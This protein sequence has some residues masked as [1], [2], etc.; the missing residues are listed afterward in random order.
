[1]SPLTKKADLHIKDFQL[2]GIWHVIID[3]TLRSEF[4]GSCIDPVRNAE[5]SYV[6]PNGAIDAAVKS[7]LDNYHHDYSARNFLFLSAVMTTSGRISGDFLRLLYILAHR[8]AANFF[9]RMGIP[10]PSSKAYKQRRGMYFYYNGAAIGLA[11]AQATAMRIDIAQ[12]KR[13]RRKQTRHV[14][15]PHYFHLPPH[16]RL[17]Q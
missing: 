14:P 16:A 2:E 12:H 8:Q 1:M 10:D 9:T 4:H 11:C 7:K 6:Y 13:P 15:D 17:H 5:A 3:V